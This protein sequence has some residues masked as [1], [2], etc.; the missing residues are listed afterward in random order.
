MAAITDEDKEKAKDLHREAFMIL[1]DVNEIEKTL[2][3]VK[4]EATELRDKY[5]AIID[6]KNG[7][8]TQCITTSGD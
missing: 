3:R 7:N 5:A 2:S 8:E 6:S 4:N 1:T